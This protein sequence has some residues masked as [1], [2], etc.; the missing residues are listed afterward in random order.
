MPTYFAEVAPPHA[1][2]L[3]TGAHGS[4][5]NLGYTIAGWVGWVALVANGEGANAHGDIGLDVTLRTLNL[6]GDF[7]TQF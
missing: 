5:I 1:R 6:A 2:G 3:M 7:P 4:F